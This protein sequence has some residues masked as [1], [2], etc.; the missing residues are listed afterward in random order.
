MEKNEDKIDPYVVLGQI[1][2]ATNLL[3]EIEDY[4]IFCLRRLEETANNKI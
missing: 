3:T 2:K 1:R 4:I